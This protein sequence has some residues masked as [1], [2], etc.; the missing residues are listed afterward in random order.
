MGLSDRDFFEASL[1]KMCY[2]VNRWAK[3]Q[4]E[5]AERATPGAKPQTSQSIPA[6]SL[7][8]VLKGLI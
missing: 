3:E 6:T 5:I 8:S 1:S 2:F 7:K 4:Q